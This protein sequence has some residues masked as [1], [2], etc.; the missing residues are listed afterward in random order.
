MRKPPKVFDTED[1]I[2]RTN[3]RE[4]TEI[5]KL[6]RNFTS[7]TGTWQIEVLILF[8]W[9]DFW[10]F[11]CVNFST[12][13]VCIWMNLNYFVKNALDKKCYFG[14]AFSSISRI[15][16]FTLLV[17]RLHC[18][19]LFLQWW[20]EKKSAI[21]LVQLQEENLLVNSKLTKQRPNGLLW[22]T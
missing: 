2:E 9:L 14:G 4:R 18:F 16:P 6:M 20:F 15:N 1:V 19:V 5:P 21:K 10:F 8:I 17:F 11:A 13:H 7:K 12:L 22:L 3:L